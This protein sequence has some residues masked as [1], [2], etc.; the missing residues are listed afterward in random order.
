MLGGLVLPKEYEISRSTV[1][2][3]NSEAIH[4]Y[5]G[6]LE[7]WIHWQPW[8][9]IDPSIQITLGDITRGV[10]AS[11]TWSSDSGS[12]QLKF[13]DANPYTGISYDISFNDGGNQAQSSLSYDKLGDKETRV[14]WTMKGQIETPIFG[15]YLAFFMDNLVGEPFDL[16][17][18]KLKKLVETGKPVGSK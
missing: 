1:I 17:L 2:E 10:G 12:G 14:H 16:G 4:S 13:T 18:F 7:Q 8:I 9:E 11:Q 15:A 3:A 6:D 5:T